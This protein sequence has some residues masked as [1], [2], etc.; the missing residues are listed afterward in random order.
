MCSLHF[1]A[2]NVK[3]PRLTPPVNMVRTPP[4]ICTLPSTISLPHLEHFIDACFYVERAGEPPDRTP[5]TRQL[6]FRSAPPAWFAGVGEPMANLAVVPPDSCRRPAERTSGVP[7]LRGRRFTA[8]RADEPAA[9]PHV[10]RIAE[11][12]NCVYATP[13]AYR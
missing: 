1:G 4:P 6:S 13:V 12:A 3:L 8:R 11:P 10:C 2:L 5:S 7:D 9:H